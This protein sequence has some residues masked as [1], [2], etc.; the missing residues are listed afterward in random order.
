[1]TGLKTLAGGLCVAAG[2]VSATPIPVSPTQQAQVFAVCA[3]RLSALTEHQWL[4]DGPAS[5]KTARLRDA[6]ADLLEAVEPEARAA[7]MPGTS[8]IAWRVGAKAAERALLDDALF[9]TDPGRRKRAGAAA[10]ANI[11]ACRGLILGT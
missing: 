4:T 9:A 10:E 11:A 1:M 3:G 5:E 8:T 7:G 2:M 6:F